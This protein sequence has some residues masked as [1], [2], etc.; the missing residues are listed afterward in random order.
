L[1]RA[2]RLAAAV[3][4]GL[5]L[6]LLAACSESSNGPTATVEPGTLLRVLRD[7]ETLRVWTLE[8]LLALPQQEVEIDGDVQNGPWLR[9]VLAASNVGEW[10]RAT[11][12][13]AGEGRAFGIEVEI[14]SG[15]A[16]GYI[17]DI[18]RRGTAKLAGLDLARERWVRD[19]TE[20]RIDR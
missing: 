4:A 13:G 2:P 14:E 12:V 3:V 11:V 1:P 19:M 18:T 8:E 6:A 10:T 7:G 15:P 17:L 20:I 9:D 16:D 5:A